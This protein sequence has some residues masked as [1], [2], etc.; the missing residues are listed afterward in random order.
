MRVVW[1]SIRRGET[2]REDEFP[3]PAVT[4]ERLRSADPGAGEG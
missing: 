3:T 4:A 2:T 1:Q